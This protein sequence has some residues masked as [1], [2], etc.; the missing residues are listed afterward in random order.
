MGSAE[1]TKGPLSWAPW[2][3]NVLLGGTRIWQWN[4]KKVL[5]NNIDVYSIMGNKIYGAWWRIGRDD[6]F[7][8]ECREFESRSSRHVR[9]ASSSLTVACSASARKLR[10]SVN[11]CGRERFSKAHAWKSA[12]EMDKYNIVDFVWIEQRL[13]LPLHAMYTVYAQTSQHQTIVSKT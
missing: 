3:H 8:P 5:A 9:W 10:H 7:R 12:I 11:C 4:E 1:G 13:V 6:A 2:L